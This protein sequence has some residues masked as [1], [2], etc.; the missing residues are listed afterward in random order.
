MIVCSPSRKQDESLMSKQTSDRLLSTFS[1]DRKTSTRI[2]SAENG[3]LP[4]PLSETVRKLN[5]QATSKLGEITRQTSDNAQHAA[6]IVAA[7]ELLHRSTQ[8]RQR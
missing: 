1:D 5:E 3:D 7:K 6:E 2:A 4:M 8:I